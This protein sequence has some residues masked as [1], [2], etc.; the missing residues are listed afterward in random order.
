MKARRARALSPSGPLW[1]RFDD[2]AVHVLRATLLA[3]GA[4]AY[5]YLYLYLYLR[6]DAGGIAVCA[7]ANALAGSQLHNK[8]LPCQCSCIDRISY[9]WHSLRRS[10]RSSFSVLV[11]VAPHSRTPCAAVGSCCSSTDLSGLARSGVPAAAG[12]RWRSIARRRPNHAA[13][14]RGSCL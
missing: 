1:R 14:W 3:R 7:S 8:T 4:P 13:A 12:G 9:Y 5:L 2:L 11:S 6:V 10:L